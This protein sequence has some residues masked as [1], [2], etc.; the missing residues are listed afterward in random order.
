VNDSP[1]GKETDL[2][3]PAPRQVVKPG[4][5]VT[6]YAATPGSGPAGETCR[7]CRHK[8]TVYLASK[9]VVKCAIG[10]QSN[11]GATDIKASAPACRLW[12]AK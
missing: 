11:C 12:E 6:G 5:R 3:G 9:S 10:Y 4:V 2:F 8:Q 1:G 7:T